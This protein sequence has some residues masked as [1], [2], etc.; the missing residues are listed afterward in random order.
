MVI[1]DKNAEV[2]AL[3]RRKLCFAFVNT[4]STMEIVQGMVDLL[5]KKNDLIFQEKK[6][7]KK[8]YII[9]D[10]QDK[11]FFEDRQ[12]EIYIQDNIK[13]WNL[14]NHSSKSNKKF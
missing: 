10:Y 1:V 14:W 9:K 11:V 8:S 12:E 13:N 6:D 3:N 5:M 7:V 2:G 4:V